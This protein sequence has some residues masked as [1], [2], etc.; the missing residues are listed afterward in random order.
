MGIIGKARAR[1][2]TSHRR[3]RLWRGREPGCGNGAVAA[4]GEI[5]S[6]TAGC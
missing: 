5:V 1:R 2:G 4:A 3:R 6:S